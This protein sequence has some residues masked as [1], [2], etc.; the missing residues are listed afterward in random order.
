M[1]V[2]CAVV[3]DARAVHIFSAGI[4]CR[5]CRYNAY[6]LFICKGASECWWLGMSKE[7]VILCGITGH[8]N[9]V[10]RKYYL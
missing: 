2:G 7:L 6:I 8:Y 3:Y 4:E 10:L 5:H 1:K 9:T